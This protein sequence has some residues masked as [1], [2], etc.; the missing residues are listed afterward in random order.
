MLNIDVTMSMQSVDYVLVAYQIELF[1][2]K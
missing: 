1:N 2:I